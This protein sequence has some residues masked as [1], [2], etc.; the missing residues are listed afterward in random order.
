M[1]PALAVRYFGDHGTAD[2]KKS[3]KF[4]TTVFSYHLTNPGYIFRRKF[5]TTSISNRPAFDN[6]ILDI[7]S[8][9]SY[10]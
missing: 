7:I 1:F 9:R 2:S 3:S 10:K 4:T 6:H 8:L 5:P